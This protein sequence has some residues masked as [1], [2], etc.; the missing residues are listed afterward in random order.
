META[1]VGAGV[2]ASGQYT[3]NRSGGPKTQSSSGAGPGSSCLVLMCRRGLRARRS[4]GPSPMVTAPPPCGDRPRVSVPPEL[5]AMRRAMSRPGPVEPP[6]D[7]VRVDSLRRPASRCAPSPSRFMGDNETRMYVKRPPRAVQGGPVSA[8]DDGYLRLAAIRSV[9]LGMK[10]A[11]ECRGRN[12]APF[13]ANH[14]VFSHA[15]QPC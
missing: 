11:V 6:L 10:L 3:W 12:C 15:R 7:S 13:P 14:G 1:S 5:S 2:A 9:R 8:P 4:P